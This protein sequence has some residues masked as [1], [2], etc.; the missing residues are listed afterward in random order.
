MSVL[1]AEDGALEPG[2]SLVFWTALTALL[3]AFVL[4]RAIRRLAAEPFG[5][6]QQAALPPPAGKDERS[7]AE[8]RLAEHQEAVAAYRREAFGPLPKDA[9]AVPRGRPG[10][11][12]KA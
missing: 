5:I 2:S 3:A 12:K 9:Q 7:E 6:P 4:W 8:K 1:L 11:A 10:A